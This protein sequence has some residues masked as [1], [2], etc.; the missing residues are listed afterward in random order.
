MKLSMSI[1]KQAAER[2][3][4]PALRNVEYFQRRLSA[5]AMVGIVMFP[6]YYVVWHFVFPQ[7]YENLG[8][9]I[10]GAG[11]FVPIVYSKHWPAS[12]KRFL[13]YYWYFVLLYALPFFFTFMLLKNNASEVWVSSTLVAIFLMI[14]LLDWVTLIAHFLLGAGLAIL[15]FVLTSD[16]PLP[17]FFRYDF[18]AIMLFAVVSGAMSSYDSERIRVEQERAMLA[19]A[20]SIAH[21]L[22]TPLL[23]IRAGASGIANY[24][25]SLLQAYQLARQHQL[26]VT[27]IRSAHLNALE[28]VVDRID[29][30]ANHANAIIDM[31]LVS[32]RE[33]GG[34]HQPL[35]PCSI[36]QCVDMALA[37][38]PFS[39]QERALVTWQHGTDFSFQGVELLTVHVLFNLLKNSL[40]HIAQADKGHI[41][42]YLEKSTTSN[43]LIFRDTGGGI[44]SE[45]LAHIF[46]RFYSSSSDS[47]LGAGIGLAFCRDVMDTF[48][49]TIHCNSTHGE[50]CEFVLSFPSV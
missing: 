47:A 18:L 17:P 27:T 48:G 9:R 21:E 1:F 29:H 6:L 32:V 11:L 5:F 42:I 46:T 13:P 24:L 30:E 22:R 20:G 34:S 41:A 15:A 25:P 12:F 36:A 49:G 8:L 16:A 40:R 10:L 35:V 3:I 43:R 19:T 33:Q 28:G 44:P 37:R 45:V 4:E 50:Y 7:P 26:P 2:I 39:A 14:L 31:L 23:S 38:Y